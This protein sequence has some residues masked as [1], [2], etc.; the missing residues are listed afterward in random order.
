MPTTTTTR[1][2]MMT[3]VKS[4]VANDHHAMASGRICEL[5]RGGGVV[6]LEDV[7]LLVVLLVVGGRMTLQCFR[8]KMS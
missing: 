4:T 7:V 8:C 3:D 6:F 2:L 1:T 5:G